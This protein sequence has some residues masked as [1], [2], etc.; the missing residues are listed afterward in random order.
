MLW[1]QDPLFLSDHDADH[2]AAAEVFGVDVG[3][4][5]APSAQFGDAS[6]EALD[7]SRGPR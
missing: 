7:A 2:D 1:Q 3:P 5:G 4:P 6:H